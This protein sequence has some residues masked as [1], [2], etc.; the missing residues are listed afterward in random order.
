MR[1]VL[2]FKCII[3]YDGESTY[4]KIFS[5]QHFNRY[6]DKQTANKIENNKAIICVCATLNDCLVDKISVNETKRFF[7]SSPTETNKNLIV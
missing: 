3:D 2:V 4:S 5:T 1:H 7:T 6:K